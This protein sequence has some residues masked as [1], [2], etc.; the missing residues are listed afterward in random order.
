MAKRLLCLDLHG[1]CIDF[2]R[3]FASWHEL[4]YNKLIASWPKGEYNITK[5]TGKTF[6][7]LDMEFWRGLP[8]TQEFAFMTEILKGRMVFAASKI[9]DRNGALGTY[10]WF[11][12]HFQSVPFMPCDGYKGKFFTH[13]SVLIDDCDDEIANWPG[14]SILIPRPWNSA[15]E[16]S[17]IK[18][19]LLDKLEEIERED[20]DARIENNW[21]R[22][23]GVPFGV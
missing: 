3:G 4:D 11:L 15:P 19:Y 16:V 9:H 2:V 10:M 1:V 22:P 5:I 23:E 12:E 8:P 13:E 18:Q 17:D 7:D 21:Q 6:D 14:P 20:I